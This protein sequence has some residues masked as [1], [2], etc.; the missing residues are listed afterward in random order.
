MTMESAE[1]MRHLE[2]NFAKDRPTIDTKSS[3]PNPEIASKMVKSFEESLKK[4]SK[5]A[6][7]G[8][9]GNGVKRETAKNAFFVR[10]SERMAKIN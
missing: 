6:T 5:D 3:F 1:A 8:S 9:N 10:D 2:M 7:N 4:K